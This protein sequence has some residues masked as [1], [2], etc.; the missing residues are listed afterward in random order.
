[1]PLTP[2]DI[3]LYREG[4]IGVPYVTRLTG[5]RPGPHLLVNALTH[6]NEPCGAIAL[7]HLLRSGI[8]PLRGTLTLSFAN[9][10]AYRSSESTQPGGGRFLDEDLNRLWDAATL[11][12]GPPSRERTRARELRPIVDA[13]DYLLDLHSMSL[14]GA[15]LMLAGMLDRTL[16]LAR[17]VGLPEVIVRDPGHAA[18]RRLRDYGPF[19]DPRSPKTALLVEC[20]QHNDADAADLAIVATLRLLAAL[21][22][23]E[24]GLAE[25]RAPAPAAAQRVVTVTEAVTAETRS[26][27]FAADYCG[28]EVI[29]RRGTLIARDGAREIR[30]PY[31]DCV[32]VMPSPRL[33]PGQTAVRLGR[34]TG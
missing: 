9:V 1:M 24:P 15:P 6:G 2:P 18:G 21:D 32:L 34:I 23:I 14:A 20:G 27:A 29:A 8:E 31:D 33:A 5:G 26:F 19:S 3:S 11:D 17:L 22:M 10:A 4:N 12:G 7:D 16:A 13:A 28:L 25:K 30:T